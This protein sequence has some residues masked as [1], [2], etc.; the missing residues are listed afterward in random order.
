MPERVVD[1]LPSVEDVEREL[2]RNRFEASILRTIY[3]VLK[4]RQSRERAAEH[5]HRLRESGVADGR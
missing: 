2:D 4:L 1:R 3:R 5:F